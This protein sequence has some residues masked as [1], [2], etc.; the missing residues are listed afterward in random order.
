[1]SSKDS[2]EKCVMH[3]KSGNIEIMIGK[4]QVMNL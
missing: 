4:E 3:E 1:M 2:G